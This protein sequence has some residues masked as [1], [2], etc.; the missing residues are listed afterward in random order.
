MNNKV[1]YNKLFY[2]YII[3][4]LLLNVFAMSQSR[5]PQYHTRGMLH[6]TVFNTGELGRAYDRGDNGMIKGHSSM[7]WP[8][9]SSLILNGFEYKGSHNS[10]GGGLYIS[11]FKGGVNF[12]ATCGA[13]TTAGNGQSVPV[14]GVYVNPGTITR[15]EN[16]PVLSNG[17]LNPGYNPNEA[18][19]IIVAQW[20]TIGLKVAVT[21]TSRA[22]SLPGYNS[23]IIYEYDIVNID[24]VDYKDAFVGWGYGFAP[25]MFGLERKYNRWAEG[26]LRSKDMYARYDLKRWL[27][28]NHD[29]TGS[30]ES[31]FFNLWSQSG[32]RGGLNSPQA[33][34]IFPLHYDYNN[35]STKG[36]TN[37][38]KTDDSNYVWDSNNR[39]KQPYT[40][41]YE[42][43]NIDYAKIQ[44]WLNVTARKTSPFNGAT[45][46]TAFATKYHDPSSWAY[47]K[48]RT[49][50]SWTLGYTQ[51]GSH[52]YVFGPY[53]MPKNIHLHFT[54]AEVVGY[55]AG[56]AS[57]SVYKDLGGSRGNEASTLGFNPVPSWYKEMSYA[58]IGLNG[59]TIGS[60][61]LQTHELP[62]FVTPGVVSIRDVADR[63]I[64]IYTG[65]PLVKWDSLQFEP[66]D[67]PPTGM[68]NTVSISV[69]APVL[70]IE[71]TGAAVNKITWRDQVES[72]T[73]TRLH[74]PFSHYKAYRASSALGPWQLIDSIGKHDPRYWRDSLYLV[75]DKESN[76]GEDAY[77][78]VYSVDAL[79]QRSGV[80]NFARHATQSPA[81][82][83]LEKVWVTPN[84]LILTR[85][86][87]GSSIN[88]EF[89]DKIGFMGLTKKCTI[90]IFSYSG[91]LIH[92]IEHDTPPTS[93]Y[94]QEWFQITR[95]NQMMASGIYFFTVDDAATGK[96]ITGKFAVIH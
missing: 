7:E 43:A 57:D 61:Y 78:I 15:I 28:Y 64:Q 34:G 82:L 65:N 26:D 30:P 24:T 88:G 27:S 81:A 32:N 86:G 8:P 2:N 79:G 63:A 25:S 4:M 37:Y 16:F 89:T 85:G 73:T 11:G 96:R 10:L 1:L 59:N 56:I 72:F 71:N 20:T 53:M 75:Y 3:A 36:Q 21:R 74:A 35:L 49:K 29:R 39:M 41:R 38:P 13:V 47:W 70:S 69:P 22:W 91:Q 67:T 52:G 6:Q 48:G 80:T 95:N 5:T 17:D 87:Q 84:P 68:Y 46:S 77:Y 19:E 93:G 9:N 83:T 31:T 42:N 44:T 23:F 55:G 54:I 58:N 33:V 60:N 50:P 66:K 94:E 76:L 92:T 45:D 18:E 14:T 12:T 51:P 40:N 62:W 90:R